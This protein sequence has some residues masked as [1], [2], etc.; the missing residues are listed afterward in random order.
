MITIRVYN[1][2]KTSPGTLKLEKHFIETSIGRLSFMTGKN[3][4]LSHLQSAKKY[5]FKRQ[6]YIFTQ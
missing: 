5:Y 3:F 1:C 6:S 2:I 4:T